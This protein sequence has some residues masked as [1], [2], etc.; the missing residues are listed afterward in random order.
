MKQRPP[1]YLPRPEVTSDGIATL[2]L[3]ERLYA[4]LLKLH[5]GDERHVQADLRDCIQHALTKR[6]IKA[7]DAGRPDDDDDGH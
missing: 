1:P 3:L 7:K 6:W 5:D 2:E 4:E